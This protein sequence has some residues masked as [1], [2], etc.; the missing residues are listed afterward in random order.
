MF[1]RKYKV[2]A[3]NNRMYKDFRFV[4]DNIRTLAVSKYWIAQY[5]DR[6][7]YLYNIYDVETKTLVYDFS[8]L[9]RD[10]ERVRNIILKTTPIYSDSLMKLIFNF[11]SKWEPEFKNSISIYFEDLMAIYQSQ[12]DM[13]KKQYDY[14]DNMLTTKNGTKKNS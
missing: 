8:E 4:D 11:K 9:F 3:Y 12:M 1:Q 14:I 2:V 7:R 6:T 13:Y 5:G 10:Y